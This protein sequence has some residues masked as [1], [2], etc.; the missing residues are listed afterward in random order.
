MVLPSFI[1]AG[2]DVQT[3]GASK[4]VR[5][6]QGKP[7]ELIP[8]TG[9]EPPAGESPDGKN[10]VI[11]FRQ[12]TFWIDNPSEGQ[13][14]PSFPALGTKD[15][16]GALLGLESKFR[17]MMICVQK[18]DEGEKVWGFGVS[19]FKQ[20]CDI[21]AALGESLR[22]H[23]LRVLK[24]G[25]GM[26][27]KYTIVNTGR[28]VDIEGEPETDLMEYVGPTTRP[29]IIEKLVEAGAWPPPGGDPFAAAAPKKG[30]SVGGSKPKP[31]PA[32]A[33]L[34]DIVDEPVEKPKTKKEKPVTKSEPEVKVEGADDWDDDE[35]D[36]VE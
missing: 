36:K 13:R 29:E 20:L 4:F 32:A 21:E 2:S 14:S 9:V 15:D 27:T 6:E 16:P 22:G 35:F 8:L 10:C 25:E 31:A 33:P 24:K 28:V 7:L 19:V 3:G 34:V 18:D 5:L 11:S 23:I 1:G 26:Q 17:G 12:Y 30:V